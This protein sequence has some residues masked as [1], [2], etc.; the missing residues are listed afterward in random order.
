MTIKMN[1]RQIWRSYNHTF[2]R[3]C[4]VRT[5]KHIN[6]FQAVVRSVWGV[7]WSGMVSECNGT[8]IFTG[9]RNFKIVCI[10]FETCELAKWEKWL[11]STAFGL[12]FCYDCI[13]TYDCMC[14]SN[15]AHQ[16]GATT[17]KWHNTITFVLLLFQFHL[18][19]RS[20]KCCVWH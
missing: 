1:K 16:T 7:V 12:V 9:E 5:H 18:L 14:I 10:R 8:M 13:H 3:S 4:T 11:F 15:F 19:S 20:T 6:T 2:I 17:S